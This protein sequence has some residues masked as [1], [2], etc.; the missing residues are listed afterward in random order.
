MYDLFVVANS[1][2]FRSPEGNSSDSS[3]M[4]MY[5]KFSYIVQGNFALSLILDVV[6]AH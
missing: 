4:Y 3:Y 1:N 5:N 6:C 2:T